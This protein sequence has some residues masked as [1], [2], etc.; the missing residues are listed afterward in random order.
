MRRLVFRT[1][2]MNDANLRMQSF[3]PEKLVILLD[4]VSVTISISTLFL[5]CKYN[6]SRLQAEHRTAVCR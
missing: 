2:K 5:N 3:H 6:T 4:V 1:F